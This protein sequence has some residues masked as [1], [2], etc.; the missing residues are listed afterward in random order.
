MLE[1]KDIQGDAQIAFPIVNTHCT[2]LLGLFEAVIAATWSLDSS[3]LWEEGNSTNMVG[4][5]WT[6]FDRDEEGWMKRMDEVKEYKTKHGD[7]NV[8]RIYKDTPG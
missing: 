5:G 6:G 4:C 1:E 3:L 8:P 2:S 7:C